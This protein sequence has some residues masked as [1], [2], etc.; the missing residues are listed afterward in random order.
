MSDTP[1]YYDDEAFAAQYDCLWGDHTDDLPMYEAFAQRSELP[2][3]ELG[4]G[5]GRV[6]LHLA[7]AGHAVVALD[8][9]PAM[10]ERLRAQIEPA[11]EKHIRVV[12]A[13]MRD[14]DLGEKFDLIYCAANTFQH[15]LTHE[16]QLAV[17]GRVAR[18]LS[19]GGNFV[20]E[21]RTPRA[22]DWSVERAPLDLR[23][24]RDLGGGERLVQTQSL[25][26]SA[27]AQTTTTTYLLDR[28]AAD[29][30]VRRNIVDVTLRYTGLAEFKL[31]AERAGLRVAQVYSD[32]DLS[33]FTD[34]S[35]S[36]IIVTERS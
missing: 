36:M 6:A 14:F 11:F 24:V 3:L 35:D 8:A 30:S 16:D 25:K 23:A 19:D 20:L 9:S 7:R 10:L 32:A 22:V 5:T 1:A 28:V 29:G 26:T 18:H 13:D 17:L 33:P 12:E 31:L 21:M 4:A 15:L 34:D 2:A 27:A